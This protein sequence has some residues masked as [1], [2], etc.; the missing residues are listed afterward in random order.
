[1]ARM[2]MDRSSKSFRIWACFI[3]VWGAT[4]SPQGRISAAAKHEG[5]R[6]TKPRVRT[7][8]R[9]WCRAYTAS[10]FVKA[11]TATATAAAF[12]K[13]RSSRSAAVTT[14]PPV[15]YSGTA[16]IQGMM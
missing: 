12:Q 8:P 13:P 11:D 15:R 5:A 6:M 1:M 10:A 16:A 9:D 4:I 3:H 7:T 2:R 14:T